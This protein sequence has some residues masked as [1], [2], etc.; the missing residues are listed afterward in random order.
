MKNN[1]PRVG[2]DTTPLERPFPPGVVRAVRESLA[3]L[4]ERGGLDVV[5]LAPPAGANGRALARW[6]ARE[7]PRAVR[8][9][10]LIGL[11]SFTSAYPTGGPGRRV[12][13]IHE[14][15]WR[16]GV[17]EN[18]GWRHRL[19]AALG[20]LRAD[21]VVCP[22]EHVAND[23]RRQPLLG[24][25][26]ARR[27][28]RVV[29]WG[30][31]APFAADPSP[32]TIDE[33][34]LERY[35]LGDDPFVLVLGGTREKKNLG[36]LLAGLAERQK[37]CATPLKLVVTG[38]ETQHL[39]RDLG[40]ASRLGLAR[41][42]VTPG[43]LEEADLPAL[44]RLASAVAVLSHSE[45]FGLPVLE[46][47]ASG[48]PVLVPHRSAQAEVAGEAGIVLDA[49][50]ASAV[51][52]GMER[53]LAERDSGRRERLARAAELSWDRTAQAIEALWRELA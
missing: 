5:R 4:E 18:A 1:A 21:R 53:A 28:L 52:D 50:D 24:A 15:P 38:P 36:A 23:L 39:R 42:V 3:A 49:G 10:E 6:R 44:L 31:G 16:H 9:S 46:A 26:R 8:R 33:L 20:P 35:Q 45:G 30:V 40:T 34:A 51:A 14:L 48:T 22:T 47:L 17:T 41:W 11:H 19:W 37:R 13:T 29:P 43:E 25:A 32:G 27:V 7:L 2:F 12:Q